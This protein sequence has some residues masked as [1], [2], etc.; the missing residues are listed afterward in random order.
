MCLGE[1]PAEGKLLDEYFADGKIIEQEEV[2]IKSIQEITNGDQE[3]ESFL[4]DLLKV[5]PCQ[6]PSA[7][8]ALSHVYLSHCN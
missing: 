6:R 7:E 5:N 8:E 1:I 2:S 3:L 4:R